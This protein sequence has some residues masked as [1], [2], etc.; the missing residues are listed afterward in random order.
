MDPTA[1]S[2]V[3]GGIVAQLCTLII[4][5]FNARQARLR[6]EEQR[7][8]DMEDRAAL[9]KKVV[10]TSTALADKV[11]KTSIKLAKSVKSTGDDLTKHVSQTAKDLTVR[12]DG[13]TDAA[14]EAYKEANNV[15][16]KI[17]N[18]NKRL[19]SEEEKKEE[20]K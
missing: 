11:I 7:R 6:R 3:V 8:W 13:A 15:N 5:M 20:T 17:E 18:L 10:E 2:L 16:M 12:V 19:I 14:H 9:A 4:I 1:V